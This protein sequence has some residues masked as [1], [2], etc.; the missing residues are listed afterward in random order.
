MPYDILGNPISKNTKEELEQETRW[1]WFFTGFGT[2]FIICFF[3][4]L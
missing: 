1:R 3:I 4:M 2:G